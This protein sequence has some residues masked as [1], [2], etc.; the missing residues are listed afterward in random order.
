MTMKPKLTGLAQACE[1]NREI[2]ARIG[3]KWSTLIIFALREGSLR[4]SELQRS[5][6][7]VSQRML[8]LRL[9]GLERDGLVE[10]M[11]TPTV[12]PRVDYKLTTLG[13]SLRA[14]M[15]QL[16]QWAIQHRA[17]VDAAR[18]RFDKGAAV[19]KASRPSRNK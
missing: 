2:Q 10:R 3:D 14:V 1:P 7:T 18:T 12:P 9:R 6:G 8:T 15:E 19:A 16:A 4:F 17:E 11:V 13:H 5:V